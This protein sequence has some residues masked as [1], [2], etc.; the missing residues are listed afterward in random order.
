[1]SDQNLDYATIRDNVE[2]G[3]S[4]QKWYYRF[5]FLGMHVFFFV[6]TMFAVWGT[7]VA[8]SQVRSALFDNGLAGATIVV[9][10]T[11][12][13]AM[14]ILFH[15]AALYIESG[16]AERAMREKLLMREMGDDILRK[17]YVDGRGIAGQAQTPSRRQY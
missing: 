15:A 10:P 8:D 4:R 3:V 17:G 2:K 5:I 13:W 14:V 7:V 11:I 6:V 1:M 12:L 16:P 9:L